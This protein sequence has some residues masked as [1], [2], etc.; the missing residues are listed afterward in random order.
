[1]TRLIVVLCLI[2]ALSALPQANAK[3]SATA[4]TTSSLSVFEEV[5]H[6]R[7][8]AEK[9]SREECEAVD[10]CVMCTTSDSNKYPICKETGRRQRF[11]CT[12]LIDRGEF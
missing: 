5:M 12:H 9:S 10:K 7:R 4:A 2:I 3:H 11:E 6:G 8:L 1:M